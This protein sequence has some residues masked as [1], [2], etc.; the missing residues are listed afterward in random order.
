MMLSVLHCMVIPDKNH[1]S[2]DPPDC[3]GRVTADNFETIKLKNI[4]F[5]Q[6]YYKCKGLKWEIVA[7]SA[8]KLAELISN[9]CS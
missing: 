1:I 6:I 2:D 7:C 5:V 9:G 3:T 8:L 4:H